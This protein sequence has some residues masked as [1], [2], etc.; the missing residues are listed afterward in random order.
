[1]GM[2][3]WE[4]AVGDGKRICASWLSANEGPGKR[5]VRVVRPAWLLTLASFKVGEDTLGGSGG[6]VDGGKGL[7]TLTKC[8]EET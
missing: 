5:R 7:L 2:R 3:S 4:S 6:S 8:T 1:M